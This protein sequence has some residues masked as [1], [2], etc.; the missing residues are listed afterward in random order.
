MM[1]TIRGVRGENRGIF[2]FPAKTPKVKSQKCH[3][4]FAINGSGDLQ[5]PDFWE[6]GVGDGAG[7]GVKSKVKFEKS[8]PAFIIKGYRVL[9]FPYFN[10]YSG[11]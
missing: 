7:G 8:L 4:A 5:F 3:K 10:T 9:Q 2:G 11:L 6:K 1:Q